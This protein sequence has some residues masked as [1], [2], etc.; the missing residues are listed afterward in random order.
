MEK[1]TILYVEDDKINALVV[2]KLLGRFFETIDVV[3]DGEKCLEQVKKKHYDLIL[4]D[5]N[6]GEGKMD[7]IQTMQALRLLPDY[8]QVPIFAVTSYAMPEDP[9]R[10]LDLGFDAYY[11][12]PI[13][14]QEL[15]KGI[16][17]TLSISR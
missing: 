5:I 6:L 16:S 1:I 13:N 3:T 15:A 9:Q 8:R 2:K 17:Q 7:G 4:M 14:A 12:K 11:A 10:F